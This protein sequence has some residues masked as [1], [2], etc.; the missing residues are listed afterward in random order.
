[1]PFKECSTFSSG[2]HFVQLC[3]IICEILEECIYYGEPLCQIILNLNL[4]SRRRCHLL[5]FYIF[6]SGGHFV[7]KSGTI[8]GNLVGDIMGIIWNLDQ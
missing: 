2:G 5:I 1:M 7:R 6:N 8:Y 4:W 3:R